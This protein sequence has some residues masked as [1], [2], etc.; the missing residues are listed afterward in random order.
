MSFSS[1]IRSSLSQNQEFWQTIRELEKMWEKTGPT[2]ARLDSRIE[3]YV[4]AMNDKMTRMGE[5]LVNLEMGHVEKVEGLILSQDKE[6]KVLLEE[7]GYEIT[8]AAD[9]LKLYPKEKWIRDEVSRLKAEKV[10]KMRDY[11]EQIQKKQELEDKL[12]I[13]ETEWEVK[14]VP[15]ARQ[16][17][18]LQYYLD[19]LNKEV[20]SRETRIF[21]MTERINQLMYILGYGDLDVTSVLAFIDTEG[22]IK[23][24]DLK[25]VQT[26]LQR[27]ENLREVRMEEVE[28]M[29]YSINNLYQKLNIPVNDRL[30]LA[31]GAVSGIQ[32]L[33]SESNYQDIKEELSR[34]TVLKQ[35]SMDMLVAGA[36]VRL[37]KIQHQLFKSPEEIEDFIV[38]TSTDNLDENLDLIEKEID[39]L[40]MFLEQNRN[41]VEDIW[42][43]LHLENLSEEL[44]ERMSNPNR[45]FKARGNQMVKEEKDRK[46]VN[47]IPR[48][49]ERILR[50]EMNM[51]VYD[52]PLEVFVD[53]ILERFYDSTGKRPVK[54]GSNASSTSSN[55]GNTRSSTI[56]KNPN[57]DGDDF[58]P[59]M[60][61]TEYDSLRTG[62]MIAGDSRFQYDDH[63]L[64][65]SRSRTLR[66]SQSFSDL[67]HPNFQYSQLSSISEFSTTNTAARKSNKPAVPQ[68][69]PT[70][71]QTRKSRRRSRSV[72]THRSFI[73]RSLA[74][75]NRSSLVRLGRSTGPENRPETATM[76][77]RRRS[78]S[79]VI[80]SS[81]EVNNSRF[82]QSTFPANRTGRLR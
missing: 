65:S 68:S 54:K 42:D 34:V 17:R 62:P 69:E 82:T 15:T 75:N 56:P 80:G 28:G 44:I 33:L 13:K 30:A 22:S 60:N 66:K 74:V 23:K 48:R 10:E 31:T 63:S 36:R 49:C 20:E 47:S 6:R 51:H 37:E 81:S 64:L 45:L 7:L 19:E 46:K 40:V 3:H 67:Q 71:S 1:R 52:E 2:P 27:L 58:A 4:Q 29:L 21:T 12:G 14:S 77:S 9:D 18:D 32:D 57:L 43:L 59:S 38:K 76:Q 24:A 70:L 11:L 16:K 8:E 25:K 73:P 39:I 35:K 5:E 41:L 55:L 79:V 61:S 50:Y 72:I 53:R 78:Q 26:E